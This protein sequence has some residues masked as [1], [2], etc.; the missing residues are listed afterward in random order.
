[1]NVTKITAQPTPITVLRSLLSVEELSCRTGPTWLV[2]PLSIVLGFL[3]GFV[4]GLEVVDFSLCLTVVV[5][6][7]MG[8]G[9]GVGV[10]VGVGLGVGLGM[11]G[12]VPGVGRTLISSLTLICINACIR[13][14][15]L[16]A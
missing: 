14:S 11:G 3:L 9:V 4:L 2:S 13:P 10:Y 1:M 8:V 7:W 6:E 5:L 15:T 16:E 12:K